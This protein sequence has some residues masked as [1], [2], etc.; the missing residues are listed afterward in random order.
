MTI[1]LSH[2]FTYSKILVDIFLSISHHVSDKQ[3]VKL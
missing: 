1:E 3:N 2:S